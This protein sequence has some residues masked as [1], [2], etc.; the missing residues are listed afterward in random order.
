MFTRTAS[1]TANSISL[2]ETIVLGG[3]EQW[4]LLRGQD[5]NKPILLWVHGGPGAAQIGY[6]SHYTDK[7]EKDF[8]VV[9]WDQR[10]AGLS[11]SKN[12]SKESMTVEQIV[13]DLIELVRKL[14]ARFQQ[15]KVYILGHSWGTILSYIAVQ[16]HPELFHGYI[17]VSQLVNW[18]ENERRSYELTLQMTK[19]RGQKKAY[20]QLKKLGSPPW[21]TTKSERLHNKWLGLLG[22]GMIHEGSF[23][24][25]FIQPI[26]QRTEYRI[27]DALKWLRGKVFSMSALKEELESIDLYH[28]SLN[29]QVPI[30]FCYGRYDL[31]C[32]SELAEDFYHKLQAP[33]KKWVWFEKSAH[34]PILEEG[35]VFTRFLLETVN[36]WRK[37]KGKL[38]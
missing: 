22:G 20:S 38:E 6:I 16:R 14:C 8:I 32:P 7:M 19:E 33:H 28:Y 21:R 36:E 9:N 4:I 34:T 29:L 27:F 15:E 2:L 3:V 18:Q 13:N 25:M 30:A 1:E 17:S 23:L 26:M 10:G 5:Q 37:N 12:I 24:K 35:E 11:F 31:I